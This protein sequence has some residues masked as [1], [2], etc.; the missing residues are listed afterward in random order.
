[1]FIAL[2]HGIAAALYDYGEDV[3]LHGLGRT[4]AG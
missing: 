2:S 4:F 3:C 1:M